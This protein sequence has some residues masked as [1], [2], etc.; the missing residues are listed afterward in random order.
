MASASEAELAAIFYNSCEDITLRITLEEMGRPQPPTNVTV[1]NS[2]VHGIT[3]GTMIPKNPK[4]WTCIS[5]GSS[6]GKQKDV[7]AIHGDGGKTTVLTITPR[8][9]H[10]NII[11]TCA[12]NTWHSTP[13]TNV[14]GTVGS[15]TSY[16]YYI[17]H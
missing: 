16:Y 13:Y 7:Y 6:A 2:T 1:D 8:I 14:S 11:E 15:T 5:I 9:T 12:Q 3:Q 4:Q 10:P 17:L